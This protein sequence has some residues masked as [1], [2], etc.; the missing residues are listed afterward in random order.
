MR[1]REREREREERGE[2]E[3]AGVGGENKVTDP[4]LVLGKFNL[5]ESFFS[6]QWH[7]SGEVDGSIT[8]KAADPQENQ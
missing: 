5:K 6:D 2:R 8:R 4:A 1:E 7:Y 3:R